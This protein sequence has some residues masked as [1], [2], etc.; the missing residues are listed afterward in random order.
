MTP[1]LRP[2]RRSNVELNG[3]GTS[4]RAVCQ[5]VD[6]VVRQLVWTGA[7]PAAWDHLWG[8]VEVGGVMMVAPP[9]DVKSLA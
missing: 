6:G 4:K 8:V 9:T 2:V 1:K 7:A 3:G 5:G